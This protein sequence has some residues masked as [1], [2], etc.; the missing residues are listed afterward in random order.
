MKM[1][2]SENK[3]ITMICGD[4]LE[5]MPQVIESNSVDAFITDP[6]YVLTDLEFDKNHGID[7]SIK[8]LD[9]TKQNGYLI[10]FYSFLLAAKIAEYWSFRFDGIW[11]KPRGTMR[12]HSAKKPMNQQEKFFCFAHPNITQ[13]FISI[14]HIPIKRSW[15]K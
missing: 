2:Q 15:L 10:T 1:W 9:L 12:T 11:I 8:A 14:F 5:I 4:C 3:K 13:K 7:W 6:P